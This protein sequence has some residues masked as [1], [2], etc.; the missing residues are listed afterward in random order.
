MNQATEQ[1][2]ERSFED[3]LGEVQSIIARIEEGTLPLEESVRQY[4]AGMKLLNALD[5]ELKEMNRRLTVL[6]EDPEGGETEQTLE[7]TV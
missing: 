2:T 1:G 7:G 5:G 4:E 3:R 6:R